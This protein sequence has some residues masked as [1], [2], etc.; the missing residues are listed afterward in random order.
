MSFLPA[1]PR[2]ARVAPVDNSFGQ[3]VP[4]KPYEARGLET[5]TSP[6]PMYQ[7]PTQ[8]GFA[9]QLP[10][11]QD[12][13]AI[14]Q[15]AAAYFAAANQ[16]FS[17]AVAQA[18]RVYMSR[19]GTAAGPPAPVPL[20]PPPAAAPLMP[21]PAAHFGGNPAETVEPP[22]AL[23]TPSEPPPSYG[24][25]VAASLAAAGVSQ[26][27]HIDPEFEFF[28]FSSV[29]GTNVLF[30]HQ[31]P[32]LLSPSPV[33]VKV[34]GP[35][36]YAFDPVLDTNAD[37]LWRFFM[38]H[39][40]PPQLHVIIQGT[41]TETRTRWVRRGNAMTTETRTVTVTDFDFCID[42]TQ[43]V[44][45][46]WSRMICVPR[47]GQRP[48]TYKETI[49]EFVKSPN[50]LKEIHLVKQL[51][52]NFDELA[53]AI[54]YSVRMTGYT[55]SV[56]VKF[57]MANSKISVF[58]SDTMSQL[59]HNTCVR[60]LCVMTCLCIIFAPIY[61]ASRKKVSNKIV[62]EYP[63]L[64][65]APEFYTRNYYLIQ[66]LALTRQKGSNPI[67]SRSFTSLSK[68]KAANMLTRQA[69]PVTSAAA[70]GSTQTGMSFLPGQPRSARVAPVD[71]SFG[72][73]VPNKPYEARGP[74]TPT[75]PPPMYQ[76]PTQPGFAQQLPPAQDGAAIA[77]D[78][79]AYFAAANQAFSY[80]VAQAP[81]V[82]MPKLPHDF[83]DL[84]QK[85]E[86]KIL[87]PKDCPQFSSPSD[88]PVQDSDFG[89][90]AHSKV[91]DRSSDEL[92]RFLMTYIG[93]PG[94]LINIRGVI[95]N[96]NP[97]HVIEDGDIEGMDSD[98]TATDE[99]NFSIDA[100]AYVAPM[101]GCI[102]C[103]PRAGRKP[104]TCQQT[105][106]EYTQSENIFKELHI[107]KQ[108]VWNFH[109]LTLAIHSCIRQ[110]GYAGTI[111]IRFKYAVNKISKRVSNTIVCE[112]PM[113]ISEA[114]FFMRNCALIQHHVKIRDCSTS[115][116]RAI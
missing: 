99:F 71:N 86:A 102:A 95:I 10:P 114:D 22:Q 100:S 87:L 58:C 66:Q 48:Q 30:P 47:D 15:D 11:A 20:M 111:V 39:V 23:M 79:A 72:Q 103:V 68:Q 113:A 49:E 9:Q 52:W 85:P 25:A 33:K 106:D 101:W 42:A 57:P 5:P 108:V 92:W 2:S 19:L 40:G 93:N 104:K 32:Q 107:M 96:G 13:A 4:N 50:K 24:D 7:T 116:V 69:A 28:D 16:A 37:E 31:T 54:I 81:R 82:Y 110:T 70:S 3:S 78:A 74:E 21:P 26:A 62:C 60:V 105:I 112:Y 51:L 44:V 80:A 46:Q 59:A 90:F 75:S 64:I 88:I 8:P 91:L 43:Y 34:E 63:M 27:P 29:P 14:A 77:Q 94:L 45:Q 56:K 65:S 55:T 97:K 35:Q 61:F 67:P 17:Y 73:S 36:V 41:H 109:A 89:F 98:W 18:P 76:T 84:R 6:P 38:T 115:C 53:Q 83:V 12:G 1:Q